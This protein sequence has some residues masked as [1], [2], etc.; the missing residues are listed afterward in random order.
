MI[1]TEALGWIAAASMLAT[2]ACQTAFSMRLFAIGAN[3]A[4]IVYSYQIGIM[5]VLLLHLALVPINVL[6]LL[7]LFRSKPQGT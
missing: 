1:D 4:F 6:S 2:F 7:K 3:L 5:P